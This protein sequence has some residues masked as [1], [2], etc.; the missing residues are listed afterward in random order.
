MGLTKRTDLGYQP[1]LEFAIVSTFV[2]ALG[3]I[4]LGNW[5]TGG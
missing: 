2:S 3:K 5:P 1:N 4:Y